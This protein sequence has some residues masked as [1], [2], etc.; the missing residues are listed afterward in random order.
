MIEMCDM[1]HAWSNELLFER[2]LSLVATS[3]RNGFRRGPSNLETSK[4]RR[5]SRKSIVR[6]IDCYF[7]LTL[8]SLPSAHSCPFVSMFVVSSHLRRA[9]KRKRLPFMDD[10]RPR[11]TEIPRCGFRERNDGE[12]RSSLWPAIIR[13]I[14]LF[15]AACTCDAQ[16][17]SKGL[18]GAIHRND[19]WE[20]V[21]TI[22]GER[23]QAYK[24]FY[25]TSQFP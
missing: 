9:T 25:K 11:G 7:R 6:A 15:V 4:L 17:G 2:S 3:A 21:T 22:E 10:R 12:N 18:I 23:D 19:K 14:N 5:G 20:T 16:A 13:Y 24:R 8:P 1:S